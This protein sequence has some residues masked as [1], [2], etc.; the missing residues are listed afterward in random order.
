MTNTEPH[1]LACAVRQLTEGDPGWWNPENQVGASV[2]GV[3]LRKGEKPSPLNYD[4]SRPGVPFVDLWQGGMDRV[5]V[6][7]Y[8]ADLSRQLIGQD[9]QV[10][11]RVTITFLGREAVKHGRPGWDRE[12]AK[13]EVTVERGHH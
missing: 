3:V 9:P 1:C 8:G 11:D 10:G 4:G 5:R 12:I 2:T 6:L 13:F 7:G